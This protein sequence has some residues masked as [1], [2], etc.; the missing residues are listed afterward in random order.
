MPSKFKTTLMK[1]PIR[2]IIPFL[3]LTFLSGQISCIVHHDHGRGKQKGWHKNPNN[4]HHPGSTN[5]GK[6]K[7]KK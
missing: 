1:I 3:L 4:P 2:L 6:G 5:P 7:G